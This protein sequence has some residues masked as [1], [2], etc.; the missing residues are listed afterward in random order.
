MIWQNL[1]YLETY[2]KID[3]DDEDALS[4]ESEGEHSNVGHSIYFRWQF[5]S[6]FSQNVHSYCKNNCKSA[7]L[8]KSIIRMQNFE[9]EYF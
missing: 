1:Y 8:Y 5:L 6:R 7:L 3:E 4:S 9:A 2:D